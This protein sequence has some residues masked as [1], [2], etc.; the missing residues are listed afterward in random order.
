MI[1]NMRHKSKLL[2]LWCKWSTCQPW[3]Q[4]F[5]DFLL[6]SSIFLGIVFY[7]TTFL[8]R[9]Y[10][11]KISTMAL[12]WFK[13]P[14]QYCVLLELHI[15]QEQLES[16]EKTKRSSVDS[17]GKKHCQNTALPHVSN[18]F[19]LTSRTSSTPPPP[20]SQAKNPISPQF[21][22]PKY[23]VFWTLF[24]LRAWL[25]ESWLP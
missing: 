1:N 23:P 15:M 14:K 8:L 20:P 10:L 2:S 3:S 18:A 12:Y 11:A 16:P 21:L 6:F 17:Y 13:I 24:T 5:P 22:V 7:W 9:G 25:F 19:L 4:M